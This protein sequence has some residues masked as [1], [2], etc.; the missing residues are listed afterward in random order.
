MLI[1]AA[2]RP[3]AGRAISATATTAAHATLSKYGGE[4]TTKPQPPTMVSEQ[5][6]PTHAHACTADI[7][8]AMLYIEEKEGEPWTS[9]ASIHKNALKDVETLRK[10]IEAGAGQ[11]EELPLAGPPSGGGGRAGSEVRSKVPSSS[12]HNQLSKE[13]ED[14]S[15]LAGRRNNKRGRGTRG[16]SSTDEEEEEARARVSPK[17]MP[18][19]S[20]QSKSSS[21]LPGSLEPSWWGR[22]G[23][24]LKDALNNNSEQLSSLQAEVGKLGKGDDFV[25]LLKNTDLSLL[26]RVAAAIK[27][28]VGMLGHMGA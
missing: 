19:M 25:A 26:E 14:I 13:Q 16:L 17:A 27:L 10:E 5:N 23:R 20:P 8:R 6:F 4:W 9:D 24:E 12:G 28:K 2:A 21:K 22:V 7:V 18:R 15:P 3:G 1:S 11:E